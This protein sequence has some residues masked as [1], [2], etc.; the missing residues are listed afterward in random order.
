MSKQNEA[1]TTEAPALKLLGRDAILAADDL[2]YEIVDVPEWGGQV[3]VKS[4]TSAER[5]SYENSCLVT[6]GKTSRYSLA[7]VRA[8]LCS[9]SIVDEKGNRLFTDAEIHI[10]GGKSAA[11]LDRVFAVASRL[12]KLN[13]ADIE[14]L[15]GE[16][17]N[18]PTAAP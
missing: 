7:D 15:A 14:Q 11:A 5:D 16:L 4:M 17:K 18:A 8:K 12:S 1:P 9:R 13:K 10:L 6:E 3:R 2:S